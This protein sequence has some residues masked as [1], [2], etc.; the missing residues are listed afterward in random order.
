[1]LVAGGRHPQFSP[2]GREIVYWTGE[3]DPA[4]ASAQAYAIRADGSGKRRLASDFAD[5][6]NP[7]WSSDGRQI[8]FEGCRTT[9]PPLPACVDW[10]AVDGQGDTPIATGAL[11]ELRS[12]ALERQGPPEVWRDGRVLVSARHGQLITLWE[13]NIPFDTRR[14]RGKAQQ[15]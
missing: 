1:L 7:I 15:V 8:L 9:S 11:P 2:D 10:W 13:V 6:R 5:A 12:E 14:V 4:V 3:R